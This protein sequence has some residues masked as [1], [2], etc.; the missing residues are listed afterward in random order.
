MSRIF[1]DVLRHFC[2]S[3]LKAEI[4]SCVLE[5]L[6]EDFGP[7]SPECVLC[8]PKL[9]ILYHY[10]LACFSFP[11]PCVGFPTVKG[12]KRLF[13]LPPTARGHGTGWTRS[14]GGFVSPLFYTF[15]AGR[16]SQFWACFFFRWEMFVSPN[17]FEDATIS[18]LRVGMSFCNGGFW[19]GIR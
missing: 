15:H 10:L 6:Q 13:F 1:A 17:S 11:W 12:P 7:F 4:C 19:L 5:N 3:L 9:G 18:I 14:L 8:Y 2:R 16:W